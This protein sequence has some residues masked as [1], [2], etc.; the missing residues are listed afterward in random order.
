[1]TDYTLSMSTKYFSGTTQQFTE[2]FV[3]AFGID[4]S[5]STKHGFY[6]GQQVFLDENIVTIIS[7]RKH[8]LMIVDNNNV[9]YFV[10]FSAVQPIT[11]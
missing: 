9:C 8:S 10:D 2:D 6:K 5:E 3:T 1:M 4:S 7:I 11:Y